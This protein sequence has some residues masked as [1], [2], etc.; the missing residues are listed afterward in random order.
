MKNIGTY[1]MQVIIGHEIQYT[2]VGTKVFSKGW[3]SGILCTF[4]SISLLLDLDPEP[5]SQYGIGSRRAKSMRI[6]IHKISI[7]YNQG[8]VA[9]AAWWQALFR[10]TRRTESARQ[11]APNL[12]HTKGK[13]SLVCGDTLQ[14]VC[15]TV[16]AFHTETA[17][18]IP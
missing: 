1:F 16:S 6:R 4:W 14:N 5:H 8:T 17:F 18:F 12:T 7:I 10:S 9:A 13:T 15:C 11:Y 3:K 2:Y